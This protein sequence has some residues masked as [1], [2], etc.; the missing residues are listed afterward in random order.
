VGRN[1]LRDR[2]RCRSERSD[3]HARG[4][5][6]DGATIL[7]ARCF[8]AIISTRGTLAVVEGVLADVPGI[9]AALGAGAAA[10]GGSTTFSGNFEA[11]LVRIAR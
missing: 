10:P 1:R 11:A 4:D 6:N 5:D 3:T 2:R 8:R 7:V 9:V